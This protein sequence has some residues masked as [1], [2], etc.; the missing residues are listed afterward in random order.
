MFCSFAARPQSNSLYTPS[1]RS[2]QGCTSLPCTSLRVS[3]L[4]GDVERRD[5]TADACRVFN[6]HASQILLSQILLS[7]GLYS[8]I[9]LA[10]TLDPRSVP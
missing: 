4:L 5:P 6:V 7:A 1:N 2:L 3:F 9:P 8:F 10:A